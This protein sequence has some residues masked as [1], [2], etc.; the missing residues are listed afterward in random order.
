M[1]EKDTPQQNT[2]TTDEVIENYT[3]LRFWHNSTCFISAFM[4]CCMT[5]AVIWGIFNPELRFV[6]ISAGAVLGLCGIVLFIVVHRLFIKTSKTMLDYFR[7][8]CKMPDVEI[9]EK[10]KELKIPKKAFNAK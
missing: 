2:I 4:V 1:K 8:V 7:S 9:L 5:A 6:L 3:I 10:A